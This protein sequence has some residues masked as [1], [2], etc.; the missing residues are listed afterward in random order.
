METD[1]QTQ[2]YQCY[3][4]EILRLNNGADSI[5]AKPMTMS[6]TSVVIVKRDRLDEPLLKMPMVT[7]V[8]DVSSKKLLYTK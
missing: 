6:F 8:H 3:S 4:V 5:N 2:K 1:T 7:P